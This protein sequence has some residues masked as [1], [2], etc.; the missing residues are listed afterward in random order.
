MHIFILKHHA[1][2]KEHESAMAY[3][4]A[5]S[6][7]AY[8]T[9]YVTIQCGSITFHALVSCDDPPE[10][11]IYWL[12]HILFSRMGSSISCRQQSKVEVE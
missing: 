3:I 8:A 7:C 9:L 4:A 12:N 2:C 5:L 1:L 6:P 10:R 11:P